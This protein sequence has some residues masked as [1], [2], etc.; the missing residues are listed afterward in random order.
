ML[1]ILSAK[2]L[3]QMRAWRH[4]GMLSQEEFHACGKGYTFRFPLQDQGT[5]IVTNLA[6]AREHTAPLEEAPHAPRHKF[7]N[8]SILLSK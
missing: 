4:Q 1:D 3:S 8:K 6:R 2:P 5:R 7:A